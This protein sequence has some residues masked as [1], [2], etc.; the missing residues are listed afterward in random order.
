MLQLYGDAVANTSRRKATRGHWERIN[1]VCVHDMTHEAVIKLENTAPLTTINVAPTAYYNFT[2]LFRPNLLNYSN[3]SI[4]VIHCWDKKK[5]Y[6]NFIHSLST[7]DEHKKKLCILSH[8][9]SSVLLRFPQKSTQGIREAHQ[10]CSLTAAD[11]ATASHSCH[12][13]LLPTTAQCHHRHRTDEIMPPSI[14]YDNTLFIFIVVRYNNF[15]VAWCD[16][17]ARLL[18]CYMKRHK[19]RR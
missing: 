16:V 5:V 14:Y 7:I 2:M 10:R 17:Y 19:F 3:K 1:S 8:H 9:V 13:L 18:S 4:Y 6:N 11:C 15:A 12:H